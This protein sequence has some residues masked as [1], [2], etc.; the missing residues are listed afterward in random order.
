MLGICFLLGNML[1]PGAKNR[2]A[3]VFVTVLRAFLI[4][5]Q[6][7]TT[8]FLF[9]FV[10]IQTCHLANHSCARQWNAKASMCIVQWCMRVSCKP[11]SNLYYSRW[12]RECQ[13]MVIDGVPPRRAPIYQYIQLVFV[14]RC[15]L[16]AVRRPLSMLSIWVC[17]Y[18][19][20]FSLFRCPLSVVH[21]SMPFHQYIQ[22]VFVVE[23]SGVEWRGVEWSGVE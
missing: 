18:T 8:I 7:P 9:N 17:L 4:Y 1:G 10:P 21:L 19:R 14:V 20:K 6:R 2:T 13:R 3:I 16:S 5:S 22:L 23:W 15:P 11:G 12:C